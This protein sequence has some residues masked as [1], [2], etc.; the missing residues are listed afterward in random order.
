ME[1]FILQTFQDSLKSGPAE[2]VYAMPLQTV[3]IQISRL[4]KKPTD[5]DL[6]CL[7]LSM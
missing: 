6:R 3:Q 4:L 1:E 7:S 5:L 2:A